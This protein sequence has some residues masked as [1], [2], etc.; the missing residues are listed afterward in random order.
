MCISLKKASN[1]KFQYSLKLM[2]FFFQSSIQT[3]DKQK[4]QKL[5]ICLMFE[6]GR[7]FTDNLTLILPTSTIVD[8]GHAYC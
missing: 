5:N 2:M 1:G 4:L 7:L 8:L 3:L 6:Q